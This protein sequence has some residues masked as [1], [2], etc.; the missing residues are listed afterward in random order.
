MKNS[1][2]CLPSISSHQDFIILIYYRKD[3]NITSP[4]TYIAFFIFCFS[5]FPVSGSQG[6][7]LFLL[8]QHSIS[9]M[10]EVKD[11]GKF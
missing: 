5:S 9:M 3:K 2:P 6:E 8:G 10:Q 7:L 4:Q 1:S 11:R